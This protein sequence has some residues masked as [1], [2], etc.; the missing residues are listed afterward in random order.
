MSVEIYNKT[1]Q[2]TSTETHI[3]THIHMRTNT[4]HIEERAECNR[5]KY[6]LSLCHREYPLF[7]V[8]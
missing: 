3:Y 6:Q 1:T 8:L 7:P 2:C 4:M 5:L